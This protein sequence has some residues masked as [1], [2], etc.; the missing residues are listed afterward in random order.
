MDV[1][2]RE[3]SSSPP[4]PSTVRF[5]LVF[6]QTLPGVF[7]FVGIFCARLSPLRKHSY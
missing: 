4:A 1:A 2:A 7:T 3:G 6:T 5:P